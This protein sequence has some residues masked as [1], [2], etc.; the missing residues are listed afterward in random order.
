MTDQIPTIKPALR[1]LILDG[2][3]KSY[4]SVSCKD[5]VETGNRYQSVALGDERT[6]GFRSGRDVFLDR[7]DFAGKRVL[8]LG[9]N[10]GEISRAARDR[11]ASMVDGFEYDPFFVEIAQTVN[12]FNGTTRVSFYQRDITDASIYREH[13]DI[14][15]AFSVFIYLQGVLPN[16]AEITDGVLL[17]E[18]HR[19]SNNLESVYLKPISPLFPHYV[20]LGGSEWG[21]GSN[22]S[23]ERAVIAFAKSD[24]ALRA[25]VR[26]LGIFGR[27]FRSGRRRGTSPDIRFID[28]G[29][30]PWYD[31]FFTRFKGDSPEALLTE[32]DRM[33]V[34]VDGLAENGDLGTNDLAGWVYWLVYLKGALQAAGDGSPDG[35]TVYHDLL[36]RH[37]KNDPGRAKDLVDPERL[38][39]LVCR[40]FDDFKLFRSDPNAPQKAAPVQIVVTDGPPTALAR[41]G[42]K[43]IYEAGNEVPVET[44]VV[45]GYHRL[46]LA[47]LFG[48]QQVPCDFVAEADAVPDPQA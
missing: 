28:V 16:L 13:Y 25:H 15:I 40:R 23:G 17:L 32:I 4:T 47:R 29:R 9:A 2:L 37:W 41:R 33:E 7:L 3:K 36:K 21:N 48:H 24:Q 10:L 31:R 6:A 11:G 35:G 38:N 5:G 18:T 46:F 39:T 45:D 1:Q 42:V 14:V 22:P 19:L 34:D 26:G 30:T 12:A 20:I 43:R 8:D 44:T 27:Q